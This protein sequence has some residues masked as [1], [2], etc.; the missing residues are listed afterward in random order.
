M[1]NSKN[2]FEATDTNYETEVV[3]SPTLTLVD[4]WAEWCGPCK[5]LGPTIEALADEYVGKLKVYKMDVD[6]NSETAAKLQ[7]RSIPTILFYKN[8][9]IVES[10]VGNQPKEKFV[11]VIQQFS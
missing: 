6:N 9:E 8:G 3:K 11:Q 2:V 1:A 4:F 7:I 5:A 10:L